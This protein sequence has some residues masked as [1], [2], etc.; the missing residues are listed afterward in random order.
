ME[1]SGYCLVHSRMN[2][3]CW[4]GPF[5]TMAELK[6][7]AVEHHMTGVVHALYLDVDWNR[8]G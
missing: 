2:D 1:P 4:F 8:R 7:W 3:S 5:A 6:E